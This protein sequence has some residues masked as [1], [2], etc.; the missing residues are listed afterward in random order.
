LERSVEIFLVAETEDQKYA[1]YNFHSARGLNMEVS[2]ILYNLTPKFTSISLIEEK[3]KKILEFLENIETKIKEEIK[4][5]IIRKA[6]E[7]KSVWE[8][9]IFSPHIE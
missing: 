3:E 6:K 7:A 1:I 5:F 2:S 9:G 8:G 4:K